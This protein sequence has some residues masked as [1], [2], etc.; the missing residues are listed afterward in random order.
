[1]SSV[2]FQLMV[3]LEGVRQQDLIFVCL[4]QLSC[5][6]LSCPILSYPRHEREKVME[7]DYSQWHLVTRYVILEIQEILIKH[8]KKN[9][10]AMKVTEHTLPREGI[11]LSSSEILKIELDKTLSNLL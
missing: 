1:M 7:P 10:F 8:K 4:F 3:S 11:Q 9:E 6:V 2:M 5:S